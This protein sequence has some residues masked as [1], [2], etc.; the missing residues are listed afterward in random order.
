M[1]DVQEQLEAIDVQILRL[2]DERVQLC[3]RAG[4]VDDYHASEIVAL[5][6]EE[7]AE[8]GL[9]EGRI[10]KIG[11]IVAAMCKVSEE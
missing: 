2:I 7:A 8:R 3:K 5:W 6:L 10:E 11:K 4:G 1:Q 9:D